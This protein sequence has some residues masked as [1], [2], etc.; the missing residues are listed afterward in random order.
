MRASGTAHGNGCGGMSVSIGS[1]HPCGAERRHLTTKVRR[2]ISRRH[3]YHRKVS[4]PLKNESSYRKTC[5][6][7]GVVINEHISRRPPSCHEIT[8]ECVGSFAVS[9]RN[10]SDFVVRGLERI[11]FL[12]A[13]AITLGRTIIGT[14]PNCFNANGRLQQTD[15]LPQAISVE[16]LELTKTGITWSLPYYC[17]NRDRRFDSDTVTSLK[18]SVRQRSV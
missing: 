11:L 4:D 10:I 5:A 9:V 14:S 18:H 16:Y 2:T 8:R 12:H 6:V 3:G 7:D 15:A 17:E 1:Q 13:K